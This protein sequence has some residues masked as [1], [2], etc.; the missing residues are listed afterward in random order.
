MAT[1]KQIS[2]IES[3]ISKNDPTRVVD[4]TTLSVADA[5]ALIGELR[6]LEAKISSMT[7]AQLTEGMYQTADGVI[8]RVQRSRE[9]GKL[10]A[11]RLNPLGNSFEFAPGVIRTLTANDKMSLEDAKAFGVATGICCVCAA[12]LTDEK[13]VAA[14][15]GPV[16]AKKKW[17]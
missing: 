15:I 5:S 4:F 11:K 2:F 17:F 13:S 9:L 10:Y 3:L 7:I 1:E 14:G 12:F 16:C 6:Q 8:Y